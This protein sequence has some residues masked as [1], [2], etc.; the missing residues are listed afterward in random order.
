MYKHP[1]KHLILVFGFFIFL[2]GMFALLWLTPDRAFSE[3]ENRGLQTRPLFSFDSLWDGGY[4]G[5]WGEYVSDQVPFRSLWVGLHGLCEQ[6]RTGGE[7]N[8]VLSANTRHGT[9]LAVRRFNLGQTA[10]T[11]LLPSAHI[12]AQLSAVNRLSK[13]LSEKGI[14]LCVC[15]PPRTLDVTVSDFDGYPEDSINALTDCI[16]STLSHR[17]N[18]VPLLTR[19]RALHQEGTPV[20]YRTDHHWTTRGAY[21]AYLALLPCLG[22]DGEALSASDFTV[23][24]VPNFFGTTGSRAGLFGI[25]PDSLELWERAD[26]DRFA[27]RD[28]D[29]QLLMNGFFDT[30]YLAKKDKYG[31]FLG[32]NRRLITV[33]DTA[34]TGKRPR[35][36]VIKDSFANS[37]IPFLARHADLVVVNLSAGAAD[38]SALCQAYDCDRVLLVWNRENL[39]TSDVLGEI[40]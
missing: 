12:T 1:I 3:D 32:G 19:L 4:T 17:T 37:L 38:V 39:L 13:A 8:G 15:L 25:E 6:A 24:A 9:Q 29:G 40:R 31:T 36:L 14:S 34:A 16:Q 33:T 23:T 20:Y 5:R 10:A 35:L 30:S 18:F 21:E 2:G 27:V 26:D 28:E 7:S 22:L 11:D